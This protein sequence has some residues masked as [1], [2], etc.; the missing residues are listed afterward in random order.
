MQ[1]ILGILDCLFVIFAALA[2]LLNEI[3]VLVTNY[4]IKSVS[5]KF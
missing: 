3:S 1:K 4:F 5:R 2:A